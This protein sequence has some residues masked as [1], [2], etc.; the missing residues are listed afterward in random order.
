VAKA[1]KFKV[2]IQPYVVPDAAGKRLIKLAGDSGCLYEYEEFFVPDLVTEGGDDEH[3]WALTRDAA[4]ENELHDLASVTESVLFWQYGRNPSA[5][6]SSP[7]DRPDQF[8]PE[9]VFLPAQWLPEV[10]WDK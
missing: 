6:S 4:L 1:K 2:V 10:F 7:N 9:V 5:W 8:Y 3:P